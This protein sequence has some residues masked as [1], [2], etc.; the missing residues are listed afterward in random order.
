VAVSLDGLPLATARKILVQAMSEEKPSGFRTEPAGSGVERITS[1]GHDPWMVKELQGVVRLRRPDAAQLKAVA[2]GPNG[3]PVQ[4]I[5]PA[6][7]FRLLPNVLYYL[8]TP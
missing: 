4:A 3:E 5:G 1:I 2:L 6:S 8:I 7:E